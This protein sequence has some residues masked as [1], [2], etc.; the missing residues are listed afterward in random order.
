MGFFP[1]A[2]T[3]CAEPHA[4]ISQRVSRRVSCEL[5]LYAGVRLPLFA[6]TPVRVPAVARSAAEGYRRRMST[7]PRC[8]AVLSVFL[9]LS[10]CAA[11]ASRRPDIASDTSATEAPAAAFLRQLRSLCGKAFE[12]RVVA[13]TPAS[14][15]DPFAN[16]RLVMHVRECSADEVRVPFHVG[17]DHSRTW[18]I[19]HDA[20]LQSLRLKHDHRH[21]D[22]SSD[23]LTMYGGDSPAAAFPAAAA[24]RVEFPADAESQALFR[25]LDR[26]VSVDNVW[27]IE[28]D[29]RRFV[30]ELARPSRLFRV[31][32]DLTRPQPLPPAPWG[33]A[34]GRDVDVN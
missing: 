24:W 4:G 3:A 10:G 18:V 32:F 17:D 12:G 14:A 23:A 13:D 2:G 16:R 29:T 26:A 27:A 22:G 28:L 7:L 25:Q 20:G 30:Y 8:L 34:S 9:V 31:E 1:S 5:N 15:D 21:A 19:T 11:L 33:A 6:L